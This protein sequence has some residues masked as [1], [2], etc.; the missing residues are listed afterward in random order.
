MTY[1]FGADTKRLY[2]ELTSVFQKAL[3]EDEAADATGCLDA[4]LSYHRED[5]QREF[6]TACPCRAE[7]VHQ[8]GC[9]QTGEES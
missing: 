5:A 3:G 7:T 1:D 4:L 2:D 9:G 8:R 6:V